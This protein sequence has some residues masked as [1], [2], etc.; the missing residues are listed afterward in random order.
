MKC[1]DNVNKIRNYENN[2]LV[3]LIR[4]F[5]SSEKKKKKV[6]NTKISEMVFN[7]LLIL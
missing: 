1:R 4:N 2:I 6:R 5:I 7:D 3:R